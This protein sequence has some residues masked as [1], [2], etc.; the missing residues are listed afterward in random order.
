MKFLTYEA[1]TSL[2]MYLGSAA[3]AQATH[4]RSPLAPV[5]SLKGKPA[6]T[7]I[8]KA[9][10]E[11]MPSVG[12]KEEALL[13]IVAPDEFD[14]GVDR[15]LGS[16]RMGKDAAGV[17]VGLRA[18]GKAGPGHNSVDAALSG[19]VFVVQAESLDVALWK[20]GGAAV[21]LRLVQLASVRQYPISLDAIADLDLDCT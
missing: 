18:V 13:F 7:P 3:L 19:D 20:I 6:L 9:L 2:N 5:G 4:L 1:S 8:M 21:G 10:R 17:E 14:A 12:I 16:R 11:G 15:E